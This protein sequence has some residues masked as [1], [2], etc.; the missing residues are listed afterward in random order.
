MSEPLNQALAA[1]AAEVEENIVVTTKAVGRLK[2]GGGTSNFD[3]APAIA[4][5]EAAK[6]KLSAATDSLVAALDG[7]GTGTPGGGTN[8][9][10]PSSALAAAITPRYFT[11]DTV[12]PASKVAES[13]GIGTHMNYTDGEYRDPAKCAELMNYL[14]IKIFRTT[15]FHPQDQGQ[16]SIRAMMGAGFQAVPYL[17]TGTTPET[18]LSRLSEFARM[19]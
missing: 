13:V 14:G 18:Q 19:G 10:P 2:A 17:R 16:N 15:N 6:L 3:P 11:L 1:L 7:A 9:P 12:H 8:V 4:L 5:I